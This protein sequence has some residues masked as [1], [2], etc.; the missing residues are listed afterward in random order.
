VNAVW[1]G[2]EIVEG[3]A[4]LIQE[5]EVRAPVDDDS[6]PTVHKVAA[7]AV[8][9]VGNIESVPVLSIELGAV[10][11]MSPEVLADGVESPE[12]DKVKSLPVATP[13]DGFVNP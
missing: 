8:V 1:A 4:T 11:V 12:V 7:L 3:N 2:I 10:N 13:G 6:N 9:L 5:P